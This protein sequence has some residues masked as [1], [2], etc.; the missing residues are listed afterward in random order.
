MI[1]SR[2]ILTGLRCTLT[3]MNA[4]AKTKPLVRCEWPGDDQLMIDYHDTEWGRPVTDDRLHFEYLIL[5][6]AQAGLSWKTVLHKRKG[7]RKAF[8]DFDPDKVAR[9]TDKRLEKLLQDPSIIRNRLKVFSARSS[10]QAFL[11]VQKEFGSFNS[12]IWEF[13]GGKTI[14]NRWKTISDIPAETDES[15]AMSKGLKKRGFN[16]CGPTICYAYMQAAGLVNDHLTSCFCY[17]D[18]TK[19]KAGEARVA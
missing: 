11:Q 8:A 10:A 6:A 7:Y 16:F 19:K 2:L 14:L 3:C 1:P 17:K 5:D 18:I 12:Y 4:S 15:K 13:V 9:F